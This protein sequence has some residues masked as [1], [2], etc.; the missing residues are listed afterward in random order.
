MAGGISRALQLFAAHPPRGKYT[1]AECWFD[2]EL[3]ADI[4]RHRDTVSGYAR[5]WGWDRRSVRRIIAQYDRTNQTQSPPPMQ[6]ETASLNPQLDDSMPEGAPT[7]PHT[8]ESLPSGPPQGTLPGIPRAKSP[9]LR[10]LPNE[11]PAGEPIGMDE[12]E[13]WL[14]AESEKIHADVDVEMLVKGVEG[15]EAR[16]A[17]L[18]SII[19]R[20]FRAYLAGDRP[21]RGV[22]KTRKLEDA[23]EA[24]FSERDD[25]F[26]AEADDRPSARL[27]HREM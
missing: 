4:G 14:A 26:D 16:A 10:I 8:E 21:F 20:Y 22:E 6:G 5:K 23:A 17:I 11:H 19:I 12:K 18:R 13:A 7:H 2:L 24:Y 9:I 3:S 1:R 15:V 25:P 27:V